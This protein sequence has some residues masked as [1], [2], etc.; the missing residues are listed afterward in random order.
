MG[1]GQD[2]YGHRNDDV[3]HFDRDAHERTQQWVD[4]NRARSRARHGG[5]V[6]PE[7]GAAAGFLAVTGVLVA[8]VLVPFLAAG[9]WK[10]PARGEG[11]RVGAKR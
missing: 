10:K 2:P 8:A 7:T 4:E 5:V 6:Q 11:G 1:P 9:A 3:R